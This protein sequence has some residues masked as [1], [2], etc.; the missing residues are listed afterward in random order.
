MNPSLDPPNNPNKAQACMIVLCGIP[1]SGKTTVA[2]ALAA[3]AEASG[4]TTITVIH[5]DKQDG[6]LVEE[7]DPEQW[8]KD[9][10]A[11][12]EAVSKA[13]MSSNTEIN[14]T[15]TATSSDNNSSVNKN[16]GRNLV[17]VDDTMHYRSMRAECWRIARSTGAAYLYS[18]I[19]CPIE[20]ALE[21]NNHRPR[22]QR[23]P[24]EILKRTASIF[25][26]PEENQQCAYDTERYRV[27]LDLEDGVLIEGEAN[28]S[29]KITSG[30]ALWCRVEAAWG[31]P[32]PAPFDEEAEELRIV[33]AR[34]VT[35]GSLIHQV[36]VQ[37][38]KYLSEILSSIAQK[39]EQ[40][41]EES[42][43]GG[44][45]SGAKEEKKKRAEALN[46]ARRQALDTFRS[47]FLDK[48]CSSERAYEV[49]EE[50]KTYCR[51][52]LAS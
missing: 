2:T 14:Y 45:G 47:E 19:K 43:D 7:F 30:N 35:E 40:E 3:A 37:T 46:K 6:E 12:L 17:I 42:G 20:R 50:F 34:K 51:D 33:E 36:D 25:E 49:I 11:S 8:K 4:T 29:S 5:F 38:R 15:N 10:E 21:R 48:E 13:L 23:V 9:R 22:G 27:M 28:S 52:Y 44:G 39:E 18:H 16:K 1:G 31:A 24:E 41:A 26:P 32:A